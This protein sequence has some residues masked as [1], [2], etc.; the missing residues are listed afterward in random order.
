[1][2]RFPLTFLVALLS[3]C[4]A[5]CGSDGLYRFTL[6]ADGEHTFDQDLT[7]SLIITDGSVSLSAG[8]TL[9]GSVH[10]LSGSLNVDG[11][12]TGDVFFLNGD[13][14]LGPTALIGGDLNLGNGSYH[15]SPAAVIA[16]HLNT[17]GGIPLPDLP[18]RQAP[19]GWTLLLRTV[20]NG[21]LLGLAAALL[22][23]YAPAAIE[24]VGHAGVRHSL[25]SGAVGLLVGVVGISLLVT[26]A[27]TILLIP[28]T[29]LG[30]FLLGIAVLYGWIGL[31]VSAGRLGVRVLKRPVKPS[32][33]A[34]FGTLFF[35][36]V[37][38]LL[39]SLPLIGGLLG[40]MLAVV[41][42]GA[43]S[44]TRFG[45]QHFTPSTDQN[46]YS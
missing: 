24:R 8:T 13:L 18:E 41:G 14:T 11:D 4:L 7:G 12:I 20:I 36:L 39:S 42:L 9:D 44:L 26:M 31:G 21:S 30:L 10:I 23:R 22:T 33:A 2:K 1:M 29:L 6:V 19:T 45:L 16:G 17:G 35:M 25:V 46:L 15:P 5:A 43:V 3:L 37:L 40:I 34:F 32:T 27:Y 38:E 28:V